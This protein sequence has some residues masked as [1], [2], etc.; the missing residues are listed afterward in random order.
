[1]KLNRTT[2]A[3][4]TLFLWTTVHAATITVTSTADN[5]AGTLRNALASVANGDTINFTVA[6]SI[7]LSTGELVVSNSVTISGPGPGSLAVNGNAASRVFHITN[8]VTAVISG[9]TITNGVV[10]G[11][12][13]SFLGAGIWNDHSTLTLSNCIVIGN[14]VA[15]G[16]GGGLFN[17]GLSGNATL[18][19]IAST[20]SGNVASSG[21]GGLYNLSSGGTSV[22]T[23]VASTFSGNN[24][25]SVNGGGIFNDVSGGHGTIT[26]SNSTFSGN[27]CSGNGGAIANNAPTGTGTVTVVAC[28]FSANSVGS[29]SS[30][31]GIYNNGGSTTGLAVLT[32]IASTF[33][34]N[35]AATSA[36]G[37]IYNSGPNAKLEIGNTIL[38]AGATGGNIGASTATS[39]GYNL[40]SDNAS[41]LLT[42]ATDKINTDPL[43]GPLANNG[44]PTLTCAPLPGSPAIDRG[45]SFGLNTDQRGLPR[46]VDDP[47]ITNA[48]GGD[49]SDI[50]ALE[51]QTACVNLQI[52]AIT[53]ET[54]NIRITWTTY[55]GKTNA[56]QRTA[57]TPDGSY[58]TNAFTDIFTATN[59]A[60]T[61]T[62]Y[63]DIGGA[64]NK[65]ARYYRVRLV[66]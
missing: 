38:K 20:F 36:G 56:L 48:T 27:E 40:S 22:V 54:N 37:S 52:T 1:M 3:I 10:S 43:L 41:G 34:G 23:V 62:N 28:T 2:I 21:G 45:K 30:G 35:S 46:P 17:D 39:D 32:V 59:T 7:T 57:G 16:S 6:G 8:A 60:G 13:P 61:T 49:G 50:G 55:I 44:G 42:N 14:Q 5:G 66:P 33:S 18:S 9:L 47:C 63:L 26:V 31:G 25:G 4:A 11:S 65:A 51:T 15:S 29:E 64:T 19:I 58:Q 12:F 24:G 53:R